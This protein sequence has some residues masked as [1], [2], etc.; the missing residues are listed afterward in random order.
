MGFKSHHIKL[1]ALLVLMVISSVFLGWA[2]WSTRTHLAILFAF[3]VALESA[4]IYYQMSRW[5]REVLYFFR[6]LENDD[7]SISYNAVHQS[8]FVNELHGHLTR[9]NGIFQEMKLSNER[10][11]Q[12]FSRILENLSSGLMVIS[13]RGYVNHINNEALRLLNLP[14]LT[15]TRALSQWYPS[16]SGRIGEMKQLDRAEIVVLQRETGL[17]RVLGLQVL[18]INL[19]GEDVKVVTLHDLSAG[20]ERK[21]IDDWIRLIRVMSHEIMNSLAP[22][23][24][25]STTLKEMWS[26]RNPEAGGASASDSDTRIQQ[27]LKGLDAIAEQSEGLTTFFESYR[28]LSRIPDPVKQEFPVCKMFEKLETLTNHYAE[29]PAL[30]ISFQCEP[31]ELSIQADEQM[32]IQV[33]LNLVK[34]AVQAV[35]GVDGAEIGVTAVA[36]DHH[37]VLEVTDNGP[38]IPSEISDEIFMPFFT[39]REKGSGVGLSYSRQVMAMNGGRIEFDSQPGNTRFRLLF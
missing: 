39:T 25:I 30:R 4:A 7:T 32:I 9:L 15:H 37:A 6:A 31:G 11:E 38:G 8:R 1:I 18:E 21:E 27:T 34:N 14:Q 23:T 22:I 20:M 17:K 5:N 33:M 28:V 26:G 16:L 35:E 3:S 12:Y 36:E 10:R 2:L 13:R 29:D 19:K 24:S